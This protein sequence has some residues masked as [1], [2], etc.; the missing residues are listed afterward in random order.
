MYV[1]LY[2][3]EHLLLNAVYT[4]YPALFSPSNFLPELVV[5]FYNC[6]LVCL[7][8]YSSRA[9]LVALGCV[10]ATIFTQSMILLDFAIGCLICRAV[11]TLK[12]CIIAVFYW[13]GYKL[14]NF[15]VHNLLQDQNCRKSWCCYFQMMNWFQHHNFPCS[16]QNLGHIHPMYPSCH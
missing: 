1:D 11:R 6:V 8:S 15:F 9:D 12:Y 16:L 10:C 3:F 13:I 7:R 5:Q 2:S 4:L 14:H